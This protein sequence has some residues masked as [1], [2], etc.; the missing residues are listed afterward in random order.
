M[1]H[2]LIHTKQGKPL[3]GTFM[4]LITK[5]RKNTSITQEE[6]A[7]KLGITRQKLA[8]I[9]KNETELNMSQAKKI[10]DIFNISLE[11]ISNNKLNKL[12]NIVLDKKLKKNESDVQI[13]VP[14]KNIDKFKEV[15]LYVLDKV[16]A[17]PN[18]GETVIYKLLYFIDFDFY[19]KFEETLMGA[20][21]IKNHHGPTPIAFKS[22][23]DEMIADKELEKVKSSY[24][25]FPQKKYLPLRKPKLELLTGQELEHVEEV[26]ARLSDKNATE[27]SNYSHGDIPWQI[28]EEGELISYESVFYRDANY[29]VKNSNDEL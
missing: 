28:H 7:N 16:G 29:S 22:I 5:L 17:K 13:R 21:Y 25:T 6:L 3:H 18:V 11:E 10:S 20:E 9:E 4:H 27:L 26:L 2:L 24:F 12:P 15:L 8:H 14:R 19:E 1:L 23:V